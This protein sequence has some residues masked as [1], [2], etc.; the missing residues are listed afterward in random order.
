MKQ[1]TLTEAYERAGN[2]ATKR[3]EADA[4]A[5]R[6]DALAYFG[7]TE[8]EKENVMWNKILWKI[9]AMGTAAIPWERIAKAVLDKLAEKI[10]EGGATLE[11]LDPCEFLEDVEQVLASK[12]GIKIDLDGDGVAGE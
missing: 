2:L 5:R 6:K 8:T 4:I 12:L 7:M 3:Q 1:I 10:R 9:L 11:T